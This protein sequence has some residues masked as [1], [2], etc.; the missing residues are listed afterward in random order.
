MGYNYT[1]SY[2]QPMSPA[3]TLLVFA[4]SI[5]ALIA[6]WRIFQKA[7]Q[8][9]W[10]VLIPIYNA[11]VEYR[12]ICGRESAFLRL[13]IPFYNIYW[14][15]KSMIALAHAFG[16]STGFGWGLVFLSPIFLCILGFGPDQ[17][18]GPQDL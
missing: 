6:M 8:P 16:R 2:S 1:Y 4:C 5:V 18:L 15:I 11:I 9:G 3:A 7:G 17:Y 13:L 14:L 10:A 12:V